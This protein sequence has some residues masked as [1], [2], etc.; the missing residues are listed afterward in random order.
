MEPM[1]YGGSA[2]QHQHQHQHQEY[3]QDYS[4]ETEQPEE[5]AVEQWVEFCCS[6]EPPES[7][8][9][10]SSSGSGSGSTN[11]VSA[12]AFDPAYELLWSGYDSGR[13]TATFFPGSSDVSTPEQ[14]QIMQAYQQRDGWASKYCSFRAFHNSA[15]LEVL[16]L[17]NRILSV[18][19]D[20]V[21]LHSRGGMPVCTFKPL[22]LVGDDG[23]S[24]ISCGA[25][26]QP[27]GGL[28]RGVDEN[29]LLL[30][31]SSSAPQGALPCPVFDLQN[32]DVGALISI[33][34]G[35][36]STRCMQS[37]PAA[38]SFLSL[39]GADGKIRL[40]DP[41]L[42]SSTV[43]HTLDAHSGGVRS[44]SMLDD[45][46]AILSC[47]YTARAVNPYDPNSPVTVSQT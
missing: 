40:V 29:Y 14:E 45:G 26:F 20:S 41:S 46:T 24:S 33:D 43:Q 19:C 37:C 12:L 39:G 4:H 28:M 32:P 9:G 7:T 30:G 35:G 16:P 31:T 44:L 27:S 10:S 36:V 2:P 23:S 5:D 47:G 15:V 17:P 38:A 18:S 22:S 34:T 3:A 21:R 13:V 8:R 25:T 1:Y 42:R 11:G 6:L